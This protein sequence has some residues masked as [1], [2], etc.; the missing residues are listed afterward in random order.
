MYIKKSK[1]ASSQPI[2][3]C[4]TSRQEVCI[5][6]TPHMCAER[7]FIQYMKHKSKIEGVQPS[8]FTHWLHRK[9]GKISIQRIRCDGSHGTSI[10]CVFCR[11]VLDREYIHWE[12]HIGDKL[13]SSR[14]ENPPISKLTQKQRGWFASTRNPSLVSTK[15]A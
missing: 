10:P 15:A 6:N 2:V 11:K 9:L 12:A 8:G 14:D 4:E 1:M 7:R 5:G 3:V 13:V